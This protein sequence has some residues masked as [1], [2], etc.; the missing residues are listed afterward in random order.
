MRNGATA[1]AWKRCP[2][3]ARPLVHRI[4]HKAD[5]PGFQGGSEGACLISAH[6]VVIWPIYHKVMVEGRA[7]VLHV[8]AMKEV[9]I[10]LV[11]PSSS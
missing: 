9:P 11:A 8:R 3:M 1:D 7:E 2:D 5:R 6:R 4:V 10:D